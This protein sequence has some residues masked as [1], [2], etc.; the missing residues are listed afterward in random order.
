MSSNLLN[1]LAESHLETAVQIVSKMDPQDA[2]TALAELSPLLAAG[3]LQELSIDVALAV[4]EAG[5][6]ERSAQLMELAEPELMRFARLLETQDR[7]RFRSW[8]P[9]SAKERFDRALAYDEDTAGG[10]METRA[11]TLRAGLTVQQA[12]NA[13][14]RSSH[15]LYYL[16][17]LDK[18]S[19]LIGVL[20]LRDLLLSA[21]HDP[22]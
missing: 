6:G 12:I 4:L 19:R 15:Q 13:V 17:V 10:M 8:L 9:E 7:E 18:T 16:Y 22:I 21:P 2:S 1:N 5:G 20:T 3:I 11:L 14:R